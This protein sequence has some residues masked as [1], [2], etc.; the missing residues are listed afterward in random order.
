MSDPSSST[1]RSLMIAAGVLALSGW[2]GLVLLLTTALPTVGPRWLF[3][4]L[5][6]LTS[7]GTSLPFLRLLDRRFSSERDAAPPNA[8]LRQ[9]LFVGLYADLCMWL[10]INRS[11]SLP[12]AILIALGLFAIQRL[13]RLVDRSQWRP[14]R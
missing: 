11:L 9:A 12:L 6:S 2:L 8:L 1:Y 10:Q 7:T 13:L 3:F 14:W 5:L 4:F